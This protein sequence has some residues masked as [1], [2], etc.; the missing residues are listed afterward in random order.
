[1]ADCSACAGC[2]IE[3]PATGVTTSLGSLPHGTP[4]SVTQAFEQLRYL[5]GTATTR[6]G[7]SYSIDL[8]AG[9]PGNEVQFGHGACT[10]DSSDVPER[11]ACS[12]TV[13]GV[14]P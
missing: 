3:I 12:I 14:V 8:Y 9:T 13:G 7:C 4:I 1:M 10:T 5:T 2:L 6:Y 11:L